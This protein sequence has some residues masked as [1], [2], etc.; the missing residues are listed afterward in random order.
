MCESGKVERA[1]SQL[2]RA[3]RGERSQIA[4]ARRLGYRSNPITDWEHGRRF[5]TAEETLRA[6]ARVGID[7]PAAFARFHPAPP[8]PSDHGTFHLA[9]WLQQVR[10][11]TTISDLAARCGASRFA[12]AR[13]LKG[14]ARP[15]L[16]EFM[17]LA[18]A[19]TGRV[20]DLVAEL[21]DIQRV[22]AL[23]TRYEQAAA[24]KR[25]A[26]EEPWTELI[27]RLLELTRYRDLRCGDTGVLA[28]AL[29]VDLQTEQHSLQRLRQ[30]G[31]IAQ[32]D[33]RW[34]ATGTLT[35]DTR[36]N[37]H[38]LTE[39]RRHWTQVALGRMTRPEDTDWFAY[40]LASLSQHDL[41][42]VRSRLREA[43]R[44]IRAIVAASEPCEVAA[45][46]N[47]HLVSWV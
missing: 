22:P 47:L 13:W 28:N 24:A 31:V 35:V 26:Y 4:F 15:R 23:L 2:L 3:L 8:P 7:V 14:E 33:D 5:P 44:E 39:L 6:A 46:V 19:I 34:E 1:S 37:P 10:G 21:V 43:F 9:P 27:L 38:A 20:P 30:A 41:E 25:A 42:R 40:N 11:S 17:E 18:D 12:V 29:G 36:A 32:R 16:P 45:L